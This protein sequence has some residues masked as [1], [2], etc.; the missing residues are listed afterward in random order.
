MTWLAWRQLRSGVFAAAGMLAAVALVLAITRPDVSADLQAACT[1]ASGGGSD[2]C[3]VLGQQFFDDHQTA[4]LAVTG[5]LMV[6][7]GAVGLFWGAPLIAREFE[8]GTHRLAWNQ[9]VTRPCWLMVKLA[10]VGLAATLVAAA[11][12]LLVTWWA[13][14]L[15]EVGDLARIEPLLF[16]ARGIAPVGY[17]AFAFALGVT[18][19]LVVRRALPAMAI[20]AAIFAVVQLVTPAVAV[21]APADAG[22]R[23][24]RDQRLERARLRPRPRRARSRRGPARRFGRLVAVRERSRPLR[25]RGR[26]HT[27]LGFRAV[28]GTRR[29]QP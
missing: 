8:T 5:L 22:P 7:P 18:V 29:R 1:S 10:V 19:G 16:A 15:D 6:L 26:P 23:D 27:G 3:S 12:T 14:V 24:D 20:T 28:P 21:G 13:S 17:A 25:E 11:G 2:L 9:S 4:L